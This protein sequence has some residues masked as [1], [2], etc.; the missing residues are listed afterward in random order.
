MCIFIDFDKTDRP[1]KLIRKIHIK[2]ANKQKCKSGIEL[3]VSPVYVFIL[4]SFHLSTS[5]LA[6]PSF[7]FLFFFSTFRACH[8]KFRQWK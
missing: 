2:R 6:S 8:E 7:L 5:F 4:I 1:L 3:I